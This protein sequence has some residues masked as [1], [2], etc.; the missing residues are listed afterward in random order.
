VHKLEDE[1]FLEHVAWTYFV[2]AI[3]WARKY[4][5]RI[6]LDLHAV[7][8]SQNGWNHSGRGGEVGWM[9]GPLGFANGQRALDVIRIYAEY[10][11]KPEVTDVVPMFG[12]MNEPRGDTVGER[13]LKNFNYQV[14]AMVREMAGVGKGPVLS[15]FGG[16]IATS[17]WYGWL[18]HADRIMLDR[19]P[20]LIFAGAQTQDTPEQIAGQVCS[21]WGPVGREMSENFGMNSAGEWSA[22]INDCGLWINMVGAGADYDAQFGAGS[23]NT[24]NRWQNWTQTRKS[25][26][27]NFVAANMDALGDWFFWTWRIGGSLD[28]GGA[29]MSPF[30]SY[31]LGWEQ[32]WIPPD[33]REAVGACARQGHTPAR[34]FTDYEPWQTTGAGAAL[35]ATTTEAYP[36]PPAE[37]RG[38]DSYA[39]TG[40]IP[41]L[42]ATG[43]PLPSALATFVPTMPEGGMHVPWS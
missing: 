13:V 10:I 43:Y 6:N 16:F 37:M 42:V 17:A 29:V 28:D 19:H 9:N 41:T 4:G 20:Y 3:V 8:G 39:P 2:K 7:P 35:P 36:W 34:T 26:M 1:P 32:G 24:W 33:P 30:W 22:A 11:C 38:A 31:A 5:L 14:Y 25:A 40:A 21:S 12:I 23:C 27:R 15:F 18:G